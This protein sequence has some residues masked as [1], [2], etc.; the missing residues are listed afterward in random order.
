MRCTLLL[1]KKHIGSNSLSQKR[2]QLASEKGPGLFRGWRGRLPQERLTSQPRPPLRVGRCSA[3]REHEEQSRTQKGKG[4]RDR[5]NCNLAF[6][7]RAAKKPKREKN[8][9]TL[10]KPKTIKTHSRCNVHSFSRF[11]RYKNQGWNT[12][13]FVSTHPPNESILVCVFHGS[14]LH[15]FVCH[16][17]FVF[18]PLQRVRFFPGS[19]FS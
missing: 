6:G 7:R 3:P 15:T 9:V 13:F 16:F 18:L 5:I 4:R 1:T 12:N 14:L 17:N 19:P 8:Q 2:S 10:A 11:Q